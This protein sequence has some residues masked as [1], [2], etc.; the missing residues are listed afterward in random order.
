MHAELL[1]EFVS[2]WLVDSNLAAMSI[3]TGDPV[4]DPGELIELCSGAKTVFCLATLVCRGEHHIQDCR[5]LWCDM[6][7]TFRQARA[8][9]ADVPTSQD[10]LLRFY[11]IQLSRLVELTTSRIELYTITP[12]E[13]QQYVERKAD[14]TKSAPSDNQSDEQNAHVY[15]LG[16]V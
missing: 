8:A 5:R 1:S 4:D 13:R 6:L 14:E 11:L 3:R 15:S 16:R 10:P 12:A 9:W 7:E 2:G